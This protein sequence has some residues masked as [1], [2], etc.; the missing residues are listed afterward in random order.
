MR[1]PEAVRQLAV[2][3][4]PEGG[5]TAANFTLSYDAMKLGNPR[6]ALAKE[7]RLTRY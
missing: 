7:C 5:E 2:S 1:Q 3:L 4:D 6:V